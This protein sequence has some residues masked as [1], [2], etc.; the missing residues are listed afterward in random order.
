M[1]AE[2]LEATLKMAVERMR[3]YRR[4]YEQNEMA[5]RD[6][7]INPILRGLG[8]D[9]ESPEEVL[10]NV[11]TDEGIP[12]YTLMKNEKKVCSSRRRNCL[13]MWSR[14]KLFAN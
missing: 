1:K 4:F 5:V 12:D 13:W 14:G 9:P 7:I 3:N 11:S 2:M 10:P 6:Q 8:W